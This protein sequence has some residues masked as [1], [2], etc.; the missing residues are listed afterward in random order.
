MKQ[1]SMGLNCMW[2]KTC[3]LNLLQNVNKMTWNGAT[4]SKYCYLEYEND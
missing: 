1:F 4:L 3:C 2:F